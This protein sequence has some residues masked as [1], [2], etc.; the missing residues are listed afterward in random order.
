MPAL[1]PLTR[2]RRDEP[3]MPLTKHTVGNALVVCAQR[4]M[5]TEAQ[6]MAL[7]VAPD[8]EHEMVVVDLPSDLPIS[9]WDSVAALLPKRR[10]G[11]RLVVGGRSREATALA[12][13]WLS[14][15][16]GRTVVAPDGVIFRG[17]GGTL[18]VHAGK[19]SGWV[20]FRPGKAPEWEAKRFPRPLWD[21][22]LVEAWPTSAV[23]VAEPVPGGVWIHPTVRDAAF[24]GHWERLASGMPCQQEVLTVVLGCPGAPALSLDD[25]VRFW[26]RL[27][28]SVRARVR[29][30]QY[31]PV[32]LPE[33]DTLG[34]ALADL[35]QTR[36]ACYAGMPVGSPHAPDIYTMCADGN[37][38]WHAFA[39]E[40]G[41][42]P[43][44]HAAHGE[45]PALLSHRA[46]FEGLEVLSPA[47]YWY[48]PDAVV[49]VVQSGL[50]VRPPQDAQNAAA[51]RAAPVDP[52]VNV[53]AFDA[54]DERVA[55]R[56]R[57][58]AED[59][60]ARLDPATRVRCRLVA[61]SELGRGAE[62]VAGAAR[63]ELGAGPGQASARTALAEA[64]TDFV[65]P[66]SGSQPPPV[67]A[68][69]PAGLPP[70]SVPAPDF[71]AASAM[72]SRSGGGPGPAPG[73]G[74]VPGPVPERG[75]PAKGAVPEPGFPAPA[76][77]PTPDPAPVAGLIPDLAPAA[78]PI[79]D[80]ALAA[81]PAP[82]PGPAATPIPDLAP[83]AA[84]PPAP[85][86]APVPGAAAVSGVPAAAPG[87]PVRPASSDA[88]QVSVMPL[89]LE[90]S[91]APEI[92]PPPEVPG[93]PEPA[94]T[95][96]APEPEAA[97]EP[98]SPDTDRSAPPAKPRPQ[99]VPEAAASAL[100]PAQG[101]TE[102]RTWLRRTLSRE[103]DA[104]AH[105]VSRILSEHPGFQG[106]PRSSADVLTDTV[107]VRLYL[108]ERGE[109]ID[110]SLRTAANGPHVPFARCVVS[111]LSKLPSHR[112]ATVFSA[113]PTP[114]QWELYRQRRLVTEWG[115]T[116]ALTE[117]SADQEGE[118]DVLVW[119]MTA[120]RTKLLEL[121]DADRADDRVVFVP[122]TSFKVL[123][124]T[125][126]TA[127]EPR[128]RILLRELASSEVDEQGRVAERASLDELATTS[129][130][131]CVERWG[132][133]RPSGAVGESARG[134]F[135]ALPGLV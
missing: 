131:R 102:E 27:D 134:R 92:G 120:R 66:I 15:R 39:R 46:P 10:R 84:P 56:M 51:V 115:F 6:E 78:V 22:S 53:L 18:F 83:A 52:E 16:L 13:Q 43:R 88:D 4:R 67:A 108:T 128:R 63:G 110:R 73:G 117:P 58:L 60:L 87:A 90:S 36:V 85:E 109:A 111:G 101:I 94:A 33:G 23:G 24:S 126:S 32:H 42:V 97:P 100:L 14:E 80:P 74:H 104:M 25:V 19:G 47:V 86:P 35:L 114:E 127:D 28:T 20:R 54:T 30:V 11:V 72:T 59:V 82:D 129:L 17:T 49:E 71:V 124:A 62:R 3:D 75:A 113:S 132:N 40:I 68:P 121:D 21:S 125:E 76:A 34:Q 48:T 61:A 91:P 116:H 93:A 7:A 65:T 29:F 26:R 103:F 41:Y 133:A 105:S 99:P 95:T 37:L 50:W 31:G 122:G 70:I 107:A 12:G 118:I 55:A 119:S 89:R 1:P 57:L 64:A 106:D 123:E 9:T 38:G 135:G 8:T 81:A 112:G 69:P 44:G 98:P 5:T 45:T 77:A 96:E 130:R 2:R 79:P